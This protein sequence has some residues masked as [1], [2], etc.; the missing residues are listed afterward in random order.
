MD[1]NERKIALIKK[2]IHLTEQRLQNYFNDSMH[3][4]TRKSFETILINYSVI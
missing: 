3:S 2:K 4:L 1:E